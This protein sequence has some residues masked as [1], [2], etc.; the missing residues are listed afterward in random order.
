V[1]KTREID[2]N[3]YIDIDQ[4]GNVFGIELLFVKERMPS[5]LK[6]FDVEKIP[7]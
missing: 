3:T 6:R 7:A 2:R 5:S 1:R 4:K